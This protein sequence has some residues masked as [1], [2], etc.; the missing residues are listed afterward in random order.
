LPALTEKETHAGSGLPRRWF[1]AS[2]CCS[3]CRNLVANCEASLCQPLFEQRK[4]VVTPERLARE[5]KEGY[6]EH[7]VRSRLLLTAFVCLT[8]FRGEIFEIMLV[9]QAKIRNQP[10]HRF[11]LIGF[12]FAKKEFLESHPAKL[13]QSALRFGE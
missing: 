10:S 8:A 13:E 5:Q 12:E 11:R 9:G 1:A 4:P 6:A 7:V 3:G 2:K